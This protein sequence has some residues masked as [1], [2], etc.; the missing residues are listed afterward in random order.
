MNRS[1]GRRRFPSA[2]LD[3]FRRGGLDESTADGR[4]AGRLRRL[5][6]AMAASSGARAV[7]MATGIIAVP[8]TYGYLG[9]ER[10]GLWGVISSLSLALNFADL[11]LGNSLV[12]TLAEAHG[13]GDRASARRQV[14]TAFF[15]FTAI[16]AILLAVFWL[17]YPHVDWAHEFNVKSVSAAAEIGPALWCFVICL[18]AG[19]AAGVV[20]RVELAYQ[21]AFVNGIWQAVGSV[22][23]LAALLVAMRFH[24][25]L[26]GLVLALVGVP[27]LATTCQGLIVFFHT[28]PWLRPSPAWVS[29]PVASELLRLGG[30]YVVVQ[31]A[32]ALSMYSD[33]LVTTQVLGP[34]M[35]TQYNVVSKPFGLISAT[36]FMA[37]VP[38][39]PAYTEALARA[40]FQWVRRTLNRSLALV[41]ALTIVPGVLLVIV[42]PTII[43]FWVRDPSFVVPTGLL[44]ALAAWTLI[45]AIGGV[46]A[47]LMNALRIVR[48]Q[49]VCAVVT[50]VVALGAKIY[51]AKHAG[52]TGL[53]WG[54]GLSHLLFTLLPIGFY[55]RYALARRIA[56][57]AVPQ[58]T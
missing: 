14:S 25:G 12:T 53:V 58:P 13:R 16:A 4:A 42:G 34:D 52:V 21:N 51:F 32:M 48:F 36:L 45:Q 29:G 26:A 19:L 33:S 49:A 56:Q 28:R 50:S 7:S 20:S 5:V 43:R 15:L 8:L 40:D 44:I 38:M 55:L 2:F 27:V 24:V 57:G 47:A 10:Y 22:A 23:S 54:T 31:L 35:V 17:V 37:L 39:W 1:G 46:W 3:M 6:W 18:V 41:L 9:S 11:G 30:G